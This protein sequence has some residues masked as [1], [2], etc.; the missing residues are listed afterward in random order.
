MEHSGQEI[1]M[2]GHPLE[3]NKAKT[4]ISL[5][6]YTGLQN[7]TNEAEY[8]LGVARTPWKGQEYIFRQDAS[9][10]VRLTQTYNQRN[11]S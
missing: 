3:P 6:I 9:V 1:V 2:N 5:K 7:T 11:Y 10:G 8:G 4:I